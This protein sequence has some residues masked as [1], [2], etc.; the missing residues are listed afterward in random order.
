MSTKEELIERYRKQK[1]K[2]ETSGGDG[3]LF[4]TKKVGLNFFRMV[5]NPGD[6]G[7]YMEARKHRDLDKLGAV[8]QKVAFCAKSFGNT[9]A[10]C[11]ICELVAVL[12][13]SEDPVDRATAKSCKAKTTYLSYVVEL[14]SLKQKTMSDGGNV[15][16]LEYGKTILE[17]LLGYYLDTEDWG[18]FTDLEEGRNITIERTGERLDTKYEVRMRPVATKFSIDLSGLAPIEEVVAPHS[19]NKLC[20]ILGTEPDDEEEEERTTSKKKSKKAKKEVEPPEDDENEEIEEPSAP[21]LPSKKAISKLKMKALTALIDEHELDI[22]VDDYE[23]TAEIR[24]AVIELLYGPEEEEEEPVKS[25][26]KKGKAKKK[27]EPEEEEEDSDGEEDNSEKPKGAPK[28]FGDCETFDPR[29]D[30]CKTCKFM[31]ECKNI[32]L[33]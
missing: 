15:K 17:P 12:E 3:D 22:D 2:L 33:S 24:D 6:G 8:S 11:P 16:V 27:E 20:E 32:Y 14:E 7:F 31:K 23:S 1:E 21:K 19:Y 29:D 25:K 28:C 5:A 26:A 18:D 4:A 30:K 10:R 9:K 13:K